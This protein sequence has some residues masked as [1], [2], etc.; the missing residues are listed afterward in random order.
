MKSVNCLLSVILWTVSN[1]VWDN[2]TW[3]QYFAY[4]YLDFTVFCIYTNYFSIHMSRFLLPAQDEL[5]LAIQ[6]GNTLLSCIKD[7][8]S[9]TESHI[10]NSDEVENQTTAERFVKRFCRTQKV[11]QN[12]SYCYQAMPLSRYNYIAEQRENWQHTNR[13]DRAGYFWYETSQLLN[14]VIFKEIQTI[15]HCIASVQTRE[16]IVFLQ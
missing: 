16:P 9:K 4:I 1:I 6:Q 12:L 14:W 5:K 7:Q 8:A 10:L 2:K 13:E 3:Q 15:N 11:T